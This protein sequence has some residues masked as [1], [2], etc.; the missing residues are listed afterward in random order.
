M[1]L[2]GTLLGTAVW[3]LIG[4]GTAALAVSNENRI[5]GVIAIGWIMLAVFS[6]YEYHKAD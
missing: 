4:I 3:L 1:K 2:F 6:Y 5:T